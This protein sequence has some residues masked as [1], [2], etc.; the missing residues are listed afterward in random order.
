MH[1]QEALLPVRDLPAHQPLG[2]L[3]LGFLLIYALLMLFGRIADR[4]EGRTPPRRRATPAAPHQ[5]TLARRGKS[6]SPD[7]GG[8]D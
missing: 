6:S 7:G 5:V 2:V 8:G 3:I 4:W 1:P